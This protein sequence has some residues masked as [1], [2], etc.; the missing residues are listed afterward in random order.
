MLAVLKQPSIATALVLG[1]TLSAPLS[2]PAFSHAV[3]LNTTTQEQF[4]YS[5][6]AGDL[7]RLRSGRPLMV[8][9]SIAGDQVDCIWT[10]EDG[11]PRG[12]TFP[13]DVLQRF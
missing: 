8:V 6:R 4:A 9:E 11:E 1:V 12:E 5:L 3:P 10:G 7:V 13:I 2:L